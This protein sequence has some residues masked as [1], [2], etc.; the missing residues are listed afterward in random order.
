MEE[1]RVFGF[2][3][4]LLPPPLTFICSDV[5]DSALAQQGEIRTASNQRLVSQRGLAAAPDLLLCRRH[6]IIRTIT[7]L[8]WKISRMKDKNGEE[9]GLAV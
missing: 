9:V 6:G 4:T 1:K 5:I 2:S 3:L 7:M 8:L